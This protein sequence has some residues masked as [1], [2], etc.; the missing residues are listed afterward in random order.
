MYSEGGG[1]QVCTVRV[2]KGTGVHSEGAR[3]QMCTVTRSSGHNC[4]Q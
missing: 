2:G 3:A 1:A 4:V